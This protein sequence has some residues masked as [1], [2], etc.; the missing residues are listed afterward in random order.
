VKIRHPIN[1]ALVQKYIG[2]LLA[3]R[4]KI[5]RLRAKGGLNR[6][7]YCRIFLNLHICYAKMKKLRLLL[8]LGLVLPL[9]GYAQ[10]QGR[11]QDEIMLG[12]GPS[13][14]LGQLGGSSDI[15][16]HFL[17]DFNFS[18]IRFAAY[19]AYRK[20]ISYKWYIKGLVTVGELYGNDDLSSNAAR[21]NRD[22]NFKTIVIEPSLQA[23]FYFYRHDQPSHRYK[24][25][26]AHGFHASDI[27]AYVFAGVGGF[28]F[29]PEGK[30]NGTWYDLRPLSTEGE[31]LPGGLSEYSQ[32]ALSFPAGLGLKYR[33]N[34]NLIIGLE[35]SDRL[36][37]STD[38]MDDT[39]GVYFSP[40]EIAQYKGPI[41]A[42]LSHPVLGL[43]PGQDAVGQE[44]GDT[45][46]D[47][48]Y[49]FVFVTVSYRLPPQR[50]KGMGRSRYRSKF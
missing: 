27:D 9:A 36:W 43:V 30:Y 48:T 19:L 49:M 22:Q 35:L 5:S 23:E 44:R 29:N 1:G 13:Q 38:Y 40:S 32:F 34:P 39:H 31:G 3:Y 45:H 18:A 4:G 6:L 14:Y 10:Y 20:E 21:F 42:D 25:K 41:A 7:V 16:T 26:H 37:T 50:R 12:V 33:L 15:G 47:D 46:Y 8:F 28:Y 24:I 11:N 17:R 2:L